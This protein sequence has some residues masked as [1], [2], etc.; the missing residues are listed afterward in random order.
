M[1][2]FQLLGGML[3]ALLVFQFTACNNEPVLGNGGFPQQ[4]DPNEAEIGQFKAQIDGVEFIASV[5]EAV[6]TTDNLLVITGT[7]V[8]TGEIITITSEDVTGADTFNL[9][10]GS[11]TQNSGVYEIGTT[12]PYT[13]ASIV[14]GS[15]QLSITELNTTDLTVTGTFSIL[16]KRIEL[17]ANGD[18]VLDANGDPVIQSVSITPTRSSSS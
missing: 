15:G 7:N 9:I 17:D 16:G 12:Q 5:A 2:K 10:A 6:L 1:K 11:N 4:G 18:P 14:G 3:I 8:L 13:T